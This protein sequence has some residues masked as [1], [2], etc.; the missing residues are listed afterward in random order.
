MQPQTAE[1]AKNVKIAV[2]RNRKGGESRRTQ[3][4]AKRTDADIADELGVARSTVAA[5]HTGRNAIPAAH[6]ST[7]K[8][9]YRITGWPRTSG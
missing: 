3:H 8:K 6:A 4:A 1:A 7:L 5:W 9:R 2:T